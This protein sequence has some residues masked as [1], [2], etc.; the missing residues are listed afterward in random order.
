MF[1]NESYT[2]LVTH[3][4]KEELMLVGYLAWSR[5]MILI[6]FTKKGDSQW[7]EIWGEMINFVLNVEC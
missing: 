3:K 7:R 5:E 4:Y 2:K 6:P 1:L